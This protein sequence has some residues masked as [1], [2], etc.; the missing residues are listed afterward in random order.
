MTGQPPDLEPVERGTHALL[1]V[2]P[3]TALPVGFR[4]GV[5]RHVS[6]GSAVGWEWVAAAVLGLPALGFL[7]FEITNR[8]EEFGTALNNVVV[9]AT[10]DTAEAF[11]F[12][13]GTTVLAIAILGLAS[14]IAAHAAIVAPARRTST[15]R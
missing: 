7:A 8:V 12:V 3:P 5:M 6:S 4:D 13:D 14:L 1:S 15:T 9:A 10:S 11:F 2:V